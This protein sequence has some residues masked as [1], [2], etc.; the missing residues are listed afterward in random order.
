MHFPGE[1]VAFTRF[2][3]NPEKAKKHS[4]KS[5][6]SWVSW[7]TRFCMQ[8]E[9]LGFFFFFIKAYFGFHFTDYVSY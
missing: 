8:Q 4:R 5:F 9:R 6:A 3:Q 1:R 2:S 7:G